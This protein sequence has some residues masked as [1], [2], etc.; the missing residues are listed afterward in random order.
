MDGVRTLEGGCG[1]YRSDGPGSNSGR[2]KVDGRQAL[3]GAP[4]AAYSGCGEGD[5][6]I[7]TARGARGP[8]WRE[9]A[10]TFSWRG[11]WVSCR[12]AVRPGVEWRAAGPGRD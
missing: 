6:G 5:G 12:L 11:R 8:D 10:G 4:M 3:W 9:L 1:S 7:S 2:W